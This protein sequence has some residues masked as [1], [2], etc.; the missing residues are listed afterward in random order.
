MAQIAALIVLL[1]HNP[2]RGRLIQVSTGEGKT[3]ITAM[4]AA[5]C[6]ILG[7]NEHKVRIFSGIYFASKFRIIQLF[8]LNNFSRKFFKD[9]KILTIHCAGRCTH[10]KQGVG[11]K[12][13]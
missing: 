10:L 13:R 1:L 9:F 7:G 6:A 12:R 3:L 8:S 11:K 5:V 2:N 4:A